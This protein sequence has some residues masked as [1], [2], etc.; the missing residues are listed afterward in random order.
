MYNSAQAGAQDAEES[1]GRFIRGFKK[2]SSPT[3][4]HSIII[5]IS[6]LSPCQAIWRLFQ[7][8]HAQAAREL[9][10]ELDPIKEELDAAAAV[11]GQDSSENKYDRSQLPHLLKIYYK[12]LFPYDKYWEWLQYGEQG[13]RISIMFKTLSFSC[14][15]ANIQVI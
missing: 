11:G 9:A 4:W 15:R 5:I 3:H 13:A 12:S 10:M 6:D 14:K 7:K 1:G 2:Q 8:A